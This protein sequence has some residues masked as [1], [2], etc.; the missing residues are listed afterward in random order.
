MEHVVTDV[1]TSD[2]PSPN[3]FQIG[4]ALPIWPMYTHIYLERYK[5]G[6]I[7]KYNIE[8]RNKYQ[9]I[10]DLPVDRSPVLLIRA[11]VFSSASVSVS[12]LY[13]FQT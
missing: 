9:L 5:D 2:V 1:V 3:Y 12:V 11:L 4:L 6:T 7:G 10:I 8:F 13:K